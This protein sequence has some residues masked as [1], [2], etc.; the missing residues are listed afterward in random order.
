MADEAE[1]AKEVCLP[2]RGDSYVCDMCE[3]AIVVTQD[4]ACGDTPDCQPVFQCCG[5]DMTKQP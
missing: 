4:C 1:K 3:M 2:K 5:E